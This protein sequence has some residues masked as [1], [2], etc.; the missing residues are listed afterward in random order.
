[1]VSKKKAKPSRKN[2]QAAE[3]E[4]SA[5]GRPVCC[6]WL[7]AEWGLIQVWLPVNADQTPT[8]YKPIPPRRP[9]NRPGEIVAKCCLAE[10]AADLLSDCTMGECEYVSYDDG[11]G[12]LKWKLV[13]GGDRC[14]QEC[15]C[16]APPT[17]TPL[18]PGEAYIDF[19]IQ[20]SASATKKLKPL[21]AK[22]AKKR[23]AKRA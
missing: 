6:H 11:T 12:N 22:P 3:A 1:M 9:G 4:L 19:C 10:S 20:A 18:F 23:K 14:D 17:H 8:G 5:A 2:K 21:K 13:P 15:K 16:P 7:W